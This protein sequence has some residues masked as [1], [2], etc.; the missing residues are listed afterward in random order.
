MKISDLAVEFSKKLIAK[1]DYSKTVK[2]INKNII[3]TTI[4]IITDKAQTKF[5]RQKGYYT[6]L[7]IP[8]DPILQSIEKENI[9]AEISKALSETLKKYE[10]EKPKSVLVVGL[11]NPKMISDCFGAKVSEKVMVTRHISQS[12]KDESLCEVSSL[13]TNVFGLT[14]LES[15]D[16]IKGVVDRIRP[17]LVIVVDTLVAESSKRLCTNIQI[18]NVGIVPGSGVDNAR[19]KISSNSLSTPVITIGI[20][21][22]VFASS[23]FD[24]QVKKL[25]K[26][27]SGIN[28]PISIEAKGLDELV[29][30]PREIDEQVRFSSRVVANGINMALNPSL[31]QKDIETFFI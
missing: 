3:K 1:K 15:Y 2:K 14:G 12:V 20:P 27:Y 4:E 9:E 19:K 24:E 30:M 31:S 6:S 26:K 29:V 25:I 13:S 22:V 21:F 16:I 28:L 11:G 18:A 8:F 23:L 17:D 10:L 7:D 5:D